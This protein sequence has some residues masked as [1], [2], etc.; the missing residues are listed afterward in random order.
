[1]HALLGCSLMNASACAV[2]VVTFLTMPVEEESSNHTQQVGHLHACTSVQGPWTIGVRV[3][4]HTTLQVEVMLD[5]KDAFLTQDALAVVIALVGPP[6]MRHAERQMSDR[7]VLIV[8]LVVTF[9][10]NLIVI[11]DCSATSGAR[12]CWWSGRCLA[13]KTQQWPSIC[14]CFCSGSSGSHRSAMRSKLLQQ[15]FAD[16]ALELLLVMAQHT[17]EARPC[18][19]LSNALPELDIG[20]SIRG[21]IAGC[22]ARGGPAAAGDLCGTV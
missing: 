3:I 2:K 13:T 18:T 6:L 15:L 17:A 22:P 7:D 10:R 4:I 12:A 9:L 21:V 8:Q 20:E 5:I 19:G 1:M 11:P 16:S 14:C